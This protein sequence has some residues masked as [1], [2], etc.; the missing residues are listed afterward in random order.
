MSNNIFIVYVSCV[1]KFRGQT[2]KNVH[3]VRKVCRK[4]TLCVLTCFVDFY[5]FSF[6]EIN[7]RDSKLVQDH[8]WV[9][10]FQSNITKGQPRVFEKEPFTR[11]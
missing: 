10:N 11:A 9:G 2:S 8:I 5:I 6:Y 1:M 4:M 3:D 7:A